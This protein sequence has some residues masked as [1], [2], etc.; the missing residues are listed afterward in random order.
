MADS[1]GTIE[2]L[3]LVLGKM[4]KPLSTRLESGDVLGL[5]TEL[6]LGLPPLH[7][8]GAQGGLRWAASAVALAVRY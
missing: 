5:L 2:R 7:S 4:L 8:A 3:A 6:G 1:P